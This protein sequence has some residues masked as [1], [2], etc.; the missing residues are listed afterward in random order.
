M[1][2]IFLTLASANAVALILAFALGC[3]SKLTDGLHAATGS[4][5]FFHFLLGL[6]TVVGT[7]LTHSLIFTYFLGTGR[8]VKEVT[9]AYHLPDEPWHKRTRELKRLTFPPALSAMLLAEI[10]A[11]GG[12]GVQ[13]LAWPW[14][15][16]FGL[17]I[18]ALVVNLWAFRLEYRNV[19][20]NAGILDAVLRE[21]DRIRAEQ[22]LPPN[23]E[24]LKEAA[25]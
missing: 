7:L 1:T 6:F 4:L 21:V 11:A 5:Y 9:L 3:W 15:V 16:H 8:W 2:R 22:G 24:A 14:P 25:G 18:A 13:M 12:A 10:A 17:A 20:E 23:D 19:T